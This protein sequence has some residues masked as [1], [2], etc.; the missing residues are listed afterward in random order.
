MENLFKVHNSYPFCFELYTS[1]FLLS[2][3]EVFLKAQ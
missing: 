1:T 2:H 3:S